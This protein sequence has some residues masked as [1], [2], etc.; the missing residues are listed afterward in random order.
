MLD[1]IARAR[2]YVAERCS[3]AGVVERL[4]CPFLVIHGARDELVTVEEAR[5]MAE[6][7]PRGEFACFEDGYH[8]VTNYNAELVALMCDWVAD[9]LR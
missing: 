5:R 6:E 4:Q 2:D 9:R 3:L 8:T 7:A 1:S